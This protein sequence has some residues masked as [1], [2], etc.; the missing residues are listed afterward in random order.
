MQGRDVPIPNVSVQYLRLGV[1]STLTI[2]RFTLGA[3]SR[4]CGTAGSLFRPRSQIRAV[5]LVLSSRLL[6][7]NNRQFQTLCP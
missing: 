4:K 2:S 3:L 1:Q 5:W 7:R 6:V